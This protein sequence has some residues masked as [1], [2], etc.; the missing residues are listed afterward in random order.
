V[1][2]AI[3]APPAFTALCL[4]DSVIAELKLTPAT[5]GPD[6]EDTLAA[7][8]RGASATIEHYTG[9][10]FG[11]A[12][13]QELLP[14]LDMPQLLLGRTPLIAIEAVLFQQD[15][16][17]DVVIADADAGLVYR[18]R[19][20]GWTGTFV[21]G[22]LSDTRAVGSERPVYAITYRAGY[23]LPEDTAPVDPLNPRPSDGAPLLPY[24]ITRACVETVKAHWEGQSGVLIKSKSAADL[25]LTYNDIA[26]GDLPSNVKTML[27]PYRRAV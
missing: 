22:V 12:R 27:I 21:W 9:Q 19:G 15:P 11:A 26:P 16:L 2:L 20:F 24:D 3:L 17:L 14:G 25:S 23:R 5:L 7:M 13:Y 18:E 6:G 4:V 1:P 8:I 10:H